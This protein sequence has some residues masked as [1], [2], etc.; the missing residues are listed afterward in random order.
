[1]RFEPARFGWIGSPEVSNY[2]CAVLA[3][4]P[5]ERAEQLFDKEVLMAGAGAGTGTSTMPPLFS[6]L[7]GFKMKLV[8]G[9]GSSTAANLAVE[10]R[11]VHGLCQ[12]YTSL[13]AQRPGWIEDGRIKVLFNTERKPIPGL[14]APTVFQFAKTDEQRKI[15]TL[16]ASTSEFGRPIV[17]PPGTPAELIAAYRKAF[18][19][20]LTDPELLT[21]AGRQKLIVTHVRGEEL[22]GLVREMAGAPPE[23]VAKMQAMMK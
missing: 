23:L 4:S 17:T 20:V 2:V 1:V 14:P 22:E 7:L 13:K 21:E 10:R 19:A 15:L 6:R 9:Y 18:T 11:E 3:G 5:A 12:S 16:F 8:E